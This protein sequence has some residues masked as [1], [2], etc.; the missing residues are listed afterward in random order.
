[1]AAV[2]AAGGGPNA[3]SAQ[4]LIRDSEIERTLEMLATPIFEAAGVQ[5]D[6]IRIFILQDRSLNAFVTPSNSMFLH[7]GLLQRLE[8]PEEL[9]GVMAHE[10][11]HV[12]GGHIFRRIQA[13]Q[14]ARAQSILTTLLGVAA[15]AGGAGQAGTAIILGGQGVAQRG[16]LKFT[17]SQES[18]ADQAALT[19]LNRANVDPSGMLRVLRRLEQEN[20]I[21]LTGVDPYMLSHPLSSQRIQALAQ[22]V[23]ASPARNVETP[24]ETRY[25]HTRMRAKLDGFLTPPE[26]SALV[27]YG[28]EEFDLYREAIRLFRLPSPDRAV[29]TVDA[30]IALRPE[31][32]YYWELK[33]QILNDSGRGAQAIEPYRK[34]VALAPKD[35]LIAGGLGEALLSANTAEADAEALAVLERAALDDPYDASL[36]RTLAL[37]YARAGKPGLADVATAERLALTGRL[38]DAIRMA[39]RAQAQLPVGSPSWRRAEDIR[40]L[41]PDR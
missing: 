1:M 14:Q 27:S 22:G 37:A 36:L 38:D 11:G 7:T 23:A 35:A 10:T 16:L 6:G 21:G 5:Y 28:D 17:R 34:A 39:K 26:Q 32:P 4:G 31:D 33:G 9:M 25:W 13:A 20:G 30:L 3:A 19:F 41:K 15:V 29:E 2:A 18:S 8:T 24:A 40:T 12:T